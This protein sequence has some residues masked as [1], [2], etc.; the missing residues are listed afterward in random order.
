MKT[1]KVI[2]ISLLVFLLI[3]MCTKDQFNIYLKDLESAKGIS[4]NSDLNVDFYFALVD[5]ENKPISSFQ[6]GDS[7]FFYYLLKNNSDSELTYS[8]P[9]YELL[10]LLHF[11]KKDNP[12]D[13]QYHFIGKPTAYFT[14]NAVYKKIKPKSVVEL[15]RIKINYYSNWPQMDPGSYYVGDS[16]LLS[17]NHYKITYKKRIYFDI[18]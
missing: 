9:N 16:I 13:S 8:R 18:H 1:L 11:Y 2:S 14:M 17:I 10:D 15:G 3:Q 4:N 6:S 7:V 12:Q 5:R